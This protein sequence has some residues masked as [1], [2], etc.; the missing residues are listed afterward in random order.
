MPGQHSRHLCRRVV[1]VCHW[2]HR[3]SSLNVARWA[4]DGTEMETARRVGETYL[5]MSLAPEA[6]AFASVIVE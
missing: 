4:E 3:V 6:E 2:Y 5:D 1:V